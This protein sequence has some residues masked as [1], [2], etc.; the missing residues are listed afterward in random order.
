MERDALPVV[1]IGPTKPSRIPIIGPI[2][3]RLQT[4]EESVTR[5]SM[6]E[7]RAQKVADDVAAEYREKGL[8][9]TGK[10][11]PSKQRTF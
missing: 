11:R 5:F 2:L 1:E 3:D 8:R 4:R 7:N 9:A 10:T 6:P